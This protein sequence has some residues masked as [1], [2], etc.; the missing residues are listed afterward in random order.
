MKIIQDNNTVTIRDKPIN[1]TRTNKTSTT[2]HKNP[3]KQSLPQT[4]IGIKNVEDIH[5]LC[6]LAKCE[7]PLVKSSYSASL[8]NST[9]DTSQ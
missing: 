7:K 2:S 6:P 4:P 1:Q 9:T 3:R 8:A 5:F